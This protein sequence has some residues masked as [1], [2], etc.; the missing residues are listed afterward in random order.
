MNID[1]FNSV[2]IFSGEGCLAK[3]DGYREFG[4]RAFIVCGRHAARAC[5]ALA[6][7]E[8]G[9]ARNG[10]AFEIYDK[11]EPNP[12]I[13]AVYAAGRD[14]RAFGADFVIG[15]GGGSPLDAAKA[16]AAYAAN[17]ALAPEEIFTA[18]RRPALPLLAVGTTAGTGSEVTPYSIL[19]VPSMETKKS[20]AGGD[21]Y[22]RVAFLDP[23]Y[24]Y[25]LPAGQTMATAVDALCHAVEGC[26]MKKANLISDALAEKCIPM[27]ASGIRHVSAGEI[28]PEVRSELLYASSM[29]GMVISRTSTGFVHSTGY[30]LTYNHGLPHGE[31]NAYFLADFVGFMAE[32]EPER[33]AK[34]CALMGVDGADGVW[35]LVSGCPQMKLNLKLPDETLQKYA[36][37][38]C[39]AK[40]VLNAVSVIS[41]ERLLGILRKRLGE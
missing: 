40:N 33:A 36:A 26:F 34:L 22:A 6:D 24:T 25:S 20:F 30:M 9:L 18:P 16:V 15:I 7:V 17:P 35:E 21:I 38:T 12:L 8:A 32:A 3:Y 23:R 41:Q 19:T 1:F 14:A 37:R 13:S 10:I 2:K 28:T 31:A 39:G 27:L 4:S 11:I 5:G 29:A